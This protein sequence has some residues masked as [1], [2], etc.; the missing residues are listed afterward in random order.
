MK[1]NLSRIIVAVLVFLGL[2]LAL[3]IAGHYDEQ[4]QILESQSN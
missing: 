3:G 2:F 4:T 1:Q